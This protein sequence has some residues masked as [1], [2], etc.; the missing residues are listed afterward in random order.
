MALRQTESVEFGSF[1]SGSLI[2]S[3]CCAEPCKEKRGTPFSIRTL[4]RFWSP[5][6]FF[7][8]RW[9]PELALL[10]QVLALLQLLL[11]EVAAQ[12][13]VAVLI[14]PIGEV[15]TGH[16]DAGS[17]PALKLCI[18]DKGPFLHCWS[19]STDV[20]IRN[21]SGMQGLCASPTPISLAG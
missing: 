4:T 16:A 18:I 19:A 21:G 14:H 12:Q 11:P 9:C 3:D 10:F 2:R 8:P 13:G 20:L 5:A 6:N 17:F 1:P 15:L 7:L